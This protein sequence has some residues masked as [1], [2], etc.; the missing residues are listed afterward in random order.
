MCPSLANSMVWPGVLWLDCIEGRV[1]LDDSWAQ[2]VIGQGSSSCKRK[3]SNTFRRH[4]METPAATALL[5]SS[6]LW[7][8]RLIVWRSPAGALRVPQ[9]RG[10]IHPLLPFPCSEQGLQAQLWREASV[11]VTAL[12]VCTPSLEPAPV[13][14]RT[15]P[16]SHLCSTWTNS[17]DRWSVRSKSQNWAH[18]IFAEELG[19]GADMPDFPLHKTWEFESSGGQDFYSETGKAGGWEINNKNIYYL[20][21][22]ILYTLKGVER[23]TEK[24]IYIYIHKTKIYGKKYRQKAEKEISGS[25]QFLAPF[26]LKSSCFSSCV[27]KRDTLTDFLIPFLM[28]SLELAALTSNPES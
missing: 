2:T 28:S 10:F 6:V 19:I 3:R 15:A 7:P 11:S 20:F 1:G 21:L 16:R 9:V 22:K 12:W 27:P 14:S 8:E 4:R 17:A 23:D 5:N 25:F 26:L 24:N 18:H 13:H